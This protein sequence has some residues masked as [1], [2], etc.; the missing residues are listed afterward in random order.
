MPRLSMSSKRAFFTSSSGIVRIR[1]GFFQPQGI[2]ALSARLK[3]DDNVGARKLA[4][5]GA[6]HYGCTYDQGTPPWS[7]PRR[8]Q[9]E[10]S[11]PYEMNSDWA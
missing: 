7:T 6:R 1:D 11:S 2:L 5:G 8:T 9:T 10:T 3:L 4:D